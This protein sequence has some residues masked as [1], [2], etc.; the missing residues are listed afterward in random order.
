MMIKNH[1]IQAIDPSQIKMHDWRWPNFTPAEL[2]SRGNGQLYINPTALDKLQW[3]RDRLNQPMTILSAYRDPVYN[4]RIGGAQHSRHMLGDAFDI[5]LQ[6]LDKSHLIDLCHQAGFN[7]FGY[8]RTFL[9]VDCGRKR[10]W[11]G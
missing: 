3:V 6:G 2:A 5:A 10:Q 1:M 7:G 8:Y 9:H 11:Q 4:Q